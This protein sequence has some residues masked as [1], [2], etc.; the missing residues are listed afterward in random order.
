MRPRKYKGSACI[1]EDLA[2]KDNGIFVKIPIMRAATYLFL[3][4]HTAEAVLFSILLLGVEVT[5]ILYRVPEVVNKKTPQWDANPEEVTCL[6]RP[7]A[8]PNTDSKRRTP[9]HVTP[10]QREQFVTKASPGLIRFVWA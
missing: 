8:H 1:I 4:S 7:S 2:Q 9:I 5:E 6:R 3:Y 10:N